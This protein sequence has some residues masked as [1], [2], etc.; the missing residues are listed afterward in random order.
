MTTNYFYK[1]LKSKFFEVSGLDS[2]S[3]IQGLITNDINILNKNQFLYSCFLTPQGKFI[4]DFFIFKSNDKFIFEI[5][6][7]FIEII[8]KKFNIYKLKSNI[9]IRRIDLLHS[10]VIFDKLKIIKNYE[11]F[12]QY[13]VF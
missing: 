5:H 2:A 3:F 11:V 9:E 13:Y 1:N 7:K 4:A 8:L 10:F 6:E 12:N